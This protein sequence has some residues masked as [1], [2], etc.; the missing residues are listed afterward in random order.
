MRLSVDHKNGALPL[1]RNPNT[2][3][4]PIIS[5]SKQSQI[6]PG[7]ELPCGIDRF[8]AKR[9]N[10]KLVRL[11]WVNGTVTT[12]RRLCVKGSLPEPSQNGNRKETRTQRRAWRGLESVTWMVAARG[13][14]VWSASSPK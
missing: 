9:G 12:Q 1:E 11:S 7:R 4:I 10:A 8:G 13:A 2:I 6:F 5:S 14:C 3:I